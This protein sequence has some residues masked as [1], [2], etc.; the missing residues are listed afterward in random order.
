MPPN[1]IGN[2]PLIAGIVTLS[3]FFFSKQAKH[4]SHYTTALSSY[5]EFTTNHVAYDLQSQ[6]V[7]QRS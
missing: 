2:K 1:L 7:S 5:I 6:T 3:F 4:S